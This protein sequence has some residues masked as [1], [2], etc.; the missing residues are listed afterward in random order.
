MAEVTPE[1]I[2][3]QLRRMHAKQDRM[4]PTLDDLGG[5]MQRLERRIASPAAVDDEI[6]RVDH[7]LDGLDRRLGRLEDAEA[8]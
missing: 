7:R 3:A 2:A 5:R 8:T 4:Q 1:Y 6:T